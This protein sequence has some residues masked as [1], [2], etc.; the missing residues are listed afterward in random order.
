MT[1]ADTTSGIWYY[2]TN[3]GTTWNPLGAVSAGNARLLAADANTRLY[4]RPNTDYNGT[5][6]NAITFRAWDQTSG[7]AGGAADT[8]T[9]GGSTA[10]S[11]AADAAAIT[12]SAAADPPTNETLWISTAAGTTTVPP[13]NGGVTW[14]LHGDAVWFGDSN[15]ALGRRRHG[16][17]V[18]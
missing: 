17:H 16:R 3:G 7:T 4:F 1:A 6:A 8:T 18:H 12:V 2:T 9:S 14:R 5:I 11:S 10:F 15:L 13:A